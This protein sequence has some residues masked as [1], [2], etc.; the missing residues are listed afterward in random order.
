MK[1]NSGRF[2]LECLSPFLE[3]DAYSQL[4]MSGEGFLAGEILSNQENLEECL[5]VKAFSRLF[6]TGRREK[7][8]ITI[9]KE[10]WIEHWKKCDERTVSSYSGFHFGH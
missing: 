4:S 10:Q 3:G 1:E 9:A 2:R 6:K 8:L 5:E 7:T